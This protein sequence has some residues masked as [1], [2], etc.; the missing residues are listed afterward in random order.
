MRS[1][2]SRAIPKNTSDPYELERLAEELEAREVS[3][4]STSRDADR[5]EPVERPDL[6]VY[7]P[8]SHDNEYLAAETFDV[9]GFLLSRAPTSLPELRAELRDYLSSLKEELVQL[10]NDDYEDFISLSTDL[11]GEGMRLEKMRAP[12][13]TLR[14]QTMVARK[15]L[16]DTQDAVQAKLVARAKLREEKALLHLLL[17]ISESVSRLE[18]LLLI[19]QSDDG[20]NQPEI[21]AVHSG[22]LNHSSAV[23]TQGSRGKHLSRVA[24]E[25]TQLLYHISKAR[26]EKCAYVDAIQERV[27]CIR[28]T[29]MSDLDHLF[30]ATLL[31][32]TDTGDGKTLE[33][34]RAKAIAELT[35]C[36]RVYDNL[37]LWRTAEEI[38]RKNIVQPFVRKTL[39]QDALAAPSSPIVPHISIPET[40]RVPQSAHAPRTPYTP[41]TAFPT[42]GNFLDNS[43]L[44]IPFL[45]ESDNP[46]AR[47]YNQ[48]LR[49]I[50]RDLS[51]FMDI[52]ERVTLKAGTRPVELTPMLA[53]SHGELEFQGT[54]GFD[55][56]ANVIWPEI[57]QAIMD[58]L[59]SVV[60]AA[61]RPDDFLKRHAATQAFVRAL[62]FIAPTTQSVQAMRSHPVYIS[63]N[64]RWQLPIYFQLR[65]KE[66][67]GRLEDNLSTTVINPDSA[68]HGPGRSAFVTPQAELVWTSIASCWSAEVFIPDL[69]PRFWKLTLQLL[70]RYRS[71]L[72]A[73]L[74]LADPPT[75]L[76]AVDKG[77]TLQTRA[78]TLQSNYEASSENNAADDLLLKQ[79][80]TVLID[81]KVMHDQ[82]LTL[83]WEQ[84]NAALPEPI[85]PEDMDTSPE[86]VSLDALR[87]QLNSLREVSSRVERQVVALLSRRACDALSPVRSIPSQFRAM[88]SKR[89]PTESSYFILLVMRPVK[90]FFGIGTAS[91]AGARLQESFVKDAATE[92]FDSVCQRYTQYLTA[93]KKTEESLRRLKKGKK[94]TFGIFQSSNTQ[95]D[96]KDEERIQVQMML[97]V[98]GLG[99]DAQSLGIDTQRVESYVQ[100][101]QM[102]Q[103]EF[104]D[105]T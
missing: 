66:I 9:E 28:R 47:L 97:D 86:R 98:E 65:W 95:D 105:G 1:H 64:R 49:F 32:V 94:T 78:S 39:F 55:I 35:E 48:I 102:V 25:Y 14:Q 72:Q 5:E 3:S 46:L 67:I 91:S 10:I 83:W 24:M 56:L 61:G 59:G 96:D 84:I 30:S 54:Q 80:S 37:S 85:T 70:S 33:L 53:S 89:I 18:S 104:G 71:W 40:P 4:L 99:Q 6:P 7:V 57:G 36:L 22:G 34:E 52:A 38:V 43:A 82:V 13:S 8:L 88:S 76:L 63:F 60:F 11:R 100:L 17:K 92:V 23:K 93:M 90:A 50:E 44:P 87:H 31:S 69:A 101:I 16:Q 19:P 79:Y 81:I 51:Y 27:G 77:S 103:V 20:S 74:P 62:E 68:I 29:L 26:A 73:S 12:L 15:G 58:E 2:T 45:D 75:K 21:F 42:R 41:F